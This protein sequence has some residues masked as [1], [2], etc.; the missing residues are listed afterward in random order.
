M[1]TGD[2]L[3]VERVRFVCRMVF[4]WWFNSEQVEDFRENWEHPNGFD[5]WSMGVLFYLTARVASL[6]EPVVNTLFLTVD[7]RA[8]QE[9]NGVPGPSNPV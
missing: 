7:L 6:V 2:R 1:W 4:S 8:W 3:Q 9:F 5:T